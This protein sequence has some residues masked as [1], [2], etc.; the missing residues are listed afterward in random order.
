MS[1]MVLPYPHL[2][3]EMKYTATY[4]AARGDGSNGNFGAHG[5]NEGACR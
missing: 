4:D 3:H 1:L 2:T 5:F